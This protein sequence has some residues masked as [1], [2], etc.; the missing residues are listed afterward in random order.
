MS[1]YPNFIR[2]I[3]AQFMWDNTN[4]VLY[5]LKT[6]MNEFFLDITYTYAL[7]TDFFAEPRTGR[8]L[9]FTT[10]CT[11]SLGSVAISYSMLSK[12]DSRFFYVLDIL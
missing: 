10:C 5:I 7:K 12:K 6:L 2:I 3:L 4:L 11:L 1:C 8:P 9:H